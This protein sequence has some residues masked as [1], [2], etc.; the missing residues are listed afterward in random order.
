MGFIFEKISQSDKNKYKLEDSVKYW[1]I[2]RER[3]LFIYGGGAT[4]RFMQQVMEDIDFINDY[5]FFLGQNNER[6][7]V[8]LS[9]GKGTTNKAEL[10]N[11]APWVYV[12]DKFIKITDLEGNIIDDTSIFYDS[13][14]NSLKSFGGGFRNIFTPNF[15]VKFNF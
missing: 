14:K 9:K 15:V 13:I 2:D 5:V 6:Y 3:R 12:W 8:H 11:D 1:S 4:N 10:K 7:K